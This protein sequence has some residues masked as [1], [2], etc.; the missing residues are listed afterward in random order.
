MSRVII[1]GAGGGSPNRLKINDLVNNEKFFSL[2][3]QALGAMSTDDQGDVQSFFQIAGIHGLPYVV[4]DGATSHQRFNPNTHW[5]GYCTHGSVVFPTWHRPY[6]M[7][8]EQTLQQHAQKIAATY[9]VDTEAWKQAAANLRQPFW[10]WALNSTPPD[11]VIALEQVTI[12]GPNGNQIQVDNPLYH[13]N[14]HP[15]DPSFPFPYSNWQTTL[16]QPT[17][18]N[19]DA[20]DDIQQLKSVLASAQSGITTSTYNM[21]T[22]INTWPAFSNH[23]PGDGGSASN[24]LEGIHD[25]IHVDVGGQGQMADPSVAGFDPIF[26]LAPRQRG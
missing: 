4:W 20:T 17:D 5:E 11:Q 14:F 6:V 10:D 15:I 9:T 24:S 7:L 1:T 25:G 12:T 3:I 19:S 21:L 16:R 8:Y 18:E 13:Y 26:F 22:R 2:Y 23:T